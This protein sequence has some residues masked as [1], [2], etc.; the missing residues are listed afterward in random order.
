MQASATSSATATGAPPSPR[1]CQSR[2]AASIALHAGDA[3]SLR[4]VQA[5]LAA[6]A[7]AIVGVTAARAADGEVALERLVVERSISVNTA[8]AGGN[9]SLMTIA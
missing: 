4:D 5:T 3:A 7:G 2:C 6:R 9:A 8:A 1:A